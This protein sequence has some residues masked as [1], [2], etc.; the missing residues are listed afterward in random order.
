LRDTRLTRPTIDRIVPYSPG[1]PIEEVQRE[2]GLTDVI[3]LASNESPLGPSPRALAAMRAAIEDT[4]LYPD[5]TSRELTE[6]LA[7]HW[8]QPAHRIIVGRG[9]DEVIHMTG[10]AFLNPGDEVI[11]AD[12][13][14]ALYPHTA[15]VMDAAEVPVPLR[16]YVHDLEAMAAAVTPRTKL[17]FIANPHN[18]TGTMVPGAAIEALLDDMPDHVVVAIDEA[19][20]EYVERNDYER[21]LEWVDAGRNVIVYRTFSKIYA[22]AGLRVGYAIAPDHLAP[23]LAQVRPPF[24]VSS[25]GQIAAIESLRDPDQVTRGREVNRAGKSYLAREFTRLGLTF[26]PTDANFIFV[27][28]GRDCRACFDALLRRGVIVR[29]GDI[30]D[31]PT[32]V[33][34][35]IGS[36]EE[37]R[38]LVAAVEEVLREVS[39]S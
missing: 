10:L 33:R 36:A 16:D 12:P 31:L 23:A 17:I 8:G 9:S 22:L 21:A 1:K 26:P 13:P 5:N 7:E 35:S 38:I 2:L 24:N 25:V 6:R 15:R 18:P 32:H 28:L 27:D 3:K 4:R 29:T 34:I 39:P 11:Y 37:N 19:Y 30:F 20:Y 14:F